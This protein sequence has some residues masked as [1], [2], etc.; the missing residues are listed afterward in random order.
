[1]TELSAA[2]SSPAEPRRRT[3]F[4]DGLRG[5]A[6]L[7]VVGGHVVGALYNRH[8]APGEIAFTPPSKWVT[9]LNGAIAVLFSKALIAV[10]FFFVLSGFVIHLRQARSPGQE[11]RLLPYLY[12]RLR[13]LYPP[14]LLALALTAA[15][16]AAGHR[17]GYAIYFHA[18]PYPQAN[19]VVGD[20]SIKTLIGNA[21]F[22]TNL[23]VPI[24][25]S[26]GPLWSL[27]LEWWFYLLYPLLLLVN[28]RSVLAATALVLLGFLATFAEGYWPAAAPFVLL[29]KVL[30]YLPMWWAGA[31]LAEIHSGRLRGSFLPLIP[32]IVLLAVESLQS[33]IF[34]AVTPQWADRRYAIVTMASALG[35]VG[36]FAALF[37]LQRRG[38]SMRPLEKLGV[39]GDMSYTLYVTHLPIMVLIAGWYM[40]RSPDHHMPHTF[41]PAIPAVAVILLAAW[42]MHLAVEKPFSKSHLARNRVLPASIPSIDLPQ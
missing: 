26:D 29:R 22:L 5:L 38:F 14:L 25:G 3:I 7:Y 9:Y 40:N 12:R 32:L 36:V 11:F 2:I 33:H 23:T 13:R 24:Y 1:M 18:T 17:L 34:P 6:A 37:E 42:L 16:D 4:L 21:A 35:V 19:D 20:H 39:L 8:P 30:V 28:R 27:A 41:G 10:F 15:L 31:L